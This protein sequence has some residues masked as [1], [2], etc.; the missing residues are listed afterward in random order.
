MNSCQLNLSLGKCGGL[1]G[2][3]RVELRPRMWAS[4][5][6]ASTNLDCSTC[7]SVPGFAPDKALDDA[8]HH[9]TCTTHVDMWMQF[10]VPGVGPEPWPA[11]A[12]NE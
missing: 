10:Q 9:V 6:S 2:A 7:N 12:C 4:H 11:T 1:H 8:S 5:L 3:L